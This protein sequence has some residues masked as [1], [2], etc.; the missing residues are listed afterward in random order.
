MNQKLLL[1]IMYIFLIINAKKKQDYYYIITVF[2]T[3]T[4]LENMIH[5][6]HKDDNKKLIEGQANKY[7]F[8]KNFEDIMEWIGSILPFTNFLVLI[9]PTVMS[10]FKTAERGWGVGKQQ[11][12]RNIK[13]YYSSPGDY[14]RAYSSAMRSR[15]YS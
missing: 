10:F 14:D 13:Q 2:L 4:I 8:P 5:K 11:F 9:I 12:G 15:Y 1:L 6:Y 3:F 7:S